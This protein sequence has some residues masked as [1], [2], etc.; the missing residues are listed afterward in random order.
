MRKIL[1]RT[2]FFKKLAFYFTNRMAKAVKINI[3]TRA[4]FGN[5]T[6]NI[7]PVF[8]K[9][10]C[11]SE[12]RL[13]FMK[14]RSMWHKKG[15]VKADQGMPSQYLQKFI[16]LNKKQFDFLGIQ[17]YEEG[18]DL[19]LISNEFVGSVPLR[20][21]IDGK[22]I[23]DLVIL[24]RYTE[25]SEPFT[26]VTELISFLDTK[27]SPEFANWKLNSGNI[28]KPPIFYDAIKFIEVFQEAV[29]ANWRKFESIER[30]LS[31]PTASTKWDKYA[32]SSID[33]KK[34]FQFPTRINNLSTI[35]KEWQSILFVFD[36][37]VGII[38]SVKTPLNIKVQFRDKLH[39]LI[40]TNSW[41]ARKPIEKFQI[42][43]SDPLIIKKVKEQA[44]ILLE[45]GSNETKAWRLN[46][47]LFFERYIQHIFSLLSSELGAK[48]YP[49]YTY[50]KYLTGYS[51]GWVLSKIEPDIVLA[52]GEKILNIDVK[53]K[54]HMFNVS[55]N[56]V[57]LKETH[58]LDLHQIMAY[59]SFTN[60]SEKNSI[61][62]Y[63]NS[64]FSKYPIV[65]N[66]GLNN[67]KNNVYL[68]G[69][70]IGIKHVKE[71]KEHL[72]QLVSYGIFKSV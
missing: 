53:Y 36:I 33:P 12:E 49:N 19:V 69:V 37:A 67:N 47:S 23:G 6:P 35:H 11:L 24:P 18:F 64:K 2:I 48:T 3:N 54:S 7:L 27:F 20:S 21:P 63:P 10:C 46:F 59:S 4:V 70:P 15:L 26:Q 55:S 52:K 34:I 58:R 66:N 13:S 62:I 43:A 8:I 57:N 71:V 39:K 41:I 17:A 28:V 9:F 30:T 51:P 45:N 61:L 65:Y 32:I 68:L 60:G 56:S 72:K 1:L 50:R 40:S 29:K 22:V 14:L 5:N 42:N 25:N 31:Y 38:Q 16:R 44:N